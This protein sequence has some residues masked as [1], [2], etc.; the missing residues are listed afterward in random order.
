MVITQGLRDKTI[1][2]FR[3]KK[4]S[5][6][7]SEAKCEAIDMKMIFNYDAKKTHFHNKG[8]AL[9]LVLEVRFFGTRKWPIKN[10]DGRQSVSQTRPTRSTPPF[11]GLQTQTYFR[12]K[13]PPE[14]RLCSLATLS[15]F[16]AISHRSP[17][18]TGSGPL[19]PSRGGEELLRFTSS[20]LGLSL[21]FGGFSLSL[22]YLSPVPLH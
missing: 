12:E 22:F 16:Q 14:V 10:N 18:G 17:R 2:H 19:G 11:P 21:W 3:V 13:R 7:Q 8:F 6:F 1:G 20:G 9:I 5:H 4:K 15:P